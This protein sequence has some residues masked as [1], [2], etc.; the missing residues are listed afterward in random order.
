MS[1]LRCKK[2]PCSRKQF[3]ERLRSREILIVPGAYDA[4]TA[5]FVEH[6]GF[7]AVYLS[8]AGIS[9]STLGQP[10]MGLVSFSEMVEALRRVSQAVSIPVI[11]DA[12]NGYGNALNVR[13][14]VQLYEQAGAYGIQ[15]EDQAWPKKCGHLSNKTIISAQ[16]ATLKIQAAVEARQDIDTLIIAR[17]DALAVSGFDD[18]L[19]RARRYEEAGADIIFVEAPTTLEQMQQI[20]ENVSVPCLANMVEGGRTP[21]LPSLELEKIGYHLVIYPNMITRIVARQVSNALEHLRRTGSSEGLI[22]NMMLFKELNEVLGI[23]EMRALEL[24]YAVD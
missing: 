7:A 1:D 6:A 8:G 12:D 14:T 4:L 13:R 20:C 3:R 5:K 11:A 22:P 15:L 17:T 19:D 21:L 16:E 10:D 9:Y 23:D 24:N 18:A 2:A